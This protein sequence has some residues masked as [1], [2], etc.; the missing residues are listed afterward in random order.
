M[1]SFIFILIFQDAKI[2]IKTKIMSNLPTKFLP[3][4]RQN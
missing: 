1:N 3:K 4:N 2:D